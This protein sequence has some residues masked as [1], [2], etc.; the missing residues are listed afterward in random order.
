MIS[1]AL[2]TCKHSITP[3]LSPFLFPPETRTSLYCH[4]FIYEK[5]QRNT[6]GLL[7]QSVNLKRL[8]VT[9]IITYYFPE[10]F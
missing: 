1:R 3:A 6:E 5:F 2:L 9:L 8:S 10:K 4:L 7:S